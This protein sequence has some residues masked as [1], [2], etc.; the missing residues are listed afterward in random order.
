[1]IDSKDL[2]IGNCYST[3]LEV[4]GSREAKLNINENR[5]IK[6]TLNHFHIFSQAKEL[7]QCLYPIKLTESILKQCCFKTNYND[8]QDMNLFREYKLNEFIIKE[9]H[10]DK[11]FIFNGIVVE[12]LHDLQNIYYTNNNKQELP[13]D[14]NTLKI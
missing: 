1:M 12:Y 2:R 10:I 6:L 4:I 8:F 9:Y 7:I 13:I 5:V 3:G 11:K 14:I